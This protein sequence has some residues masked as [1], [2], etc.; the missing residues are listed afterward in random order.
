[1]QGVRTG[2]AAHRQGKGEQHLNLV[3]IHQAEQAIGEIAKSQTDCDA[4]ASL[5]QKQ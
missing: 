1:M 2:V 4:A 5:Q 3:A